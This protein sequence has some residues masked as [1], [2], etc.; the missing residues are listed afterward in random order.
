MKVLIY[1]LNY[2]PELTGIGKY[3]GELAHYLVENGVDVTVVTAPP[4]YPKWK[5]GEGYANSWSTEYKSGVT[6]Y[7][8]PLFVPAKPSTLKR[9]V[10]LSSFALSSTWRLIRLYKTKP[11]IVFL[12]QPTL[13]CAP[14]TLLFCK[15][16]GAKSVMHIQDYEV[17][18]MFGLGMGSEGFL[19]K[20]ARNCES[21]LIQRFDA[22]TTISYSM[23]ENAKRKGVSEDKIHFFPNWSDTEFVTPDVSGSLIKEELGLASYEK[24]ILYSGNIGQKQGL[25]VVIDAAKN[26]V[27]SPSI[28]FVII[29]SGSYRSE[30]ESLASDAQLSNITFFDLQPWARV[31]ETL[32]MADV[33]LVV[34]KKG[35]ADAGLPS[36]LIYCQLV[37]KRL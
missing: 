3:N 5:I 28:H 34:Q 15:L 25:E 6:V 24:I 1:S 35:A 30:L 20:F 9:L 4:Y 12:V 29:G 36:K 32:A 21:W 10:H 17:D 2:S 37:V 13:F 7:R 22:V 33:H 27:D 16:T 18:A 14:A 31:P 11:E 26:F 19:K 8:C 23:I